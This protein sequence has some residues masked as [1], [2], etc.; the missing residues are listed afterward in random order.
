MTKKA[1]HSVPAKPKRSRA[2]ATE[3]GASVEAPRAQ[4]LT[5]VGSHFVTS[6]VERRIAYA[7]SEK[8]E[9][10]RVDTSGSYGVR[11]A[12]D[13]ATVL[14]DGQ[15]LATTKIRARTVDPSIT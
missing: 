13:G 14:A 5:Y 12:L 11:R 2:T 9:L 7:L 1:K 15:T 8:G 10:L 4:P 3:R 6:E